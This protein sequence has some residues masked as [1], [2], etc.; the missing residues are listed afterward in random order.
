M[1]SGTRHLY[2]CRTIGSAQLAVVERS[3]YRHAALF[4]HR[5]CKID[6]NF[7]EGSDVFR[8]QPQYP[9]DLILK[10]DRYAQNTADTFSLCF[11]VVQGMNVLS[12]IP[13]DDRFS[14]PNIL[15]RQLNKLTMPHKQSLGV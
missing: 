14:F 4:G 11:L 1:P 7:R 15:T 12:G 5:H 13:D 3:L 10:N 6:I 9:N 8:E 2:L